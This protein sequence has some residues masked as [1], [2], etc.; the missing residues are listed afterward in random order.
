MF[1][2]LHAPG[3][4]AVLLDCARYFSPLIEEIPPDT[5][6]FDI[7]GLRAIHGTTEQIAQK[8]WLRV[9]IPANLAIAPNPDAAVH[10]ARG[11]KGKI[12]IAQGQEAPALAGLPL[13]LLGGSPE[14]AETL[15]LW[16]LRTFGEFAALPPMGVAA[17]LGDEG[18][19]M[20][21]LA[22]GEGDRLLKVAKDPLEFREEMEPE[23][24]LDLAESVLL[25]AGRMLND[26]CTRLSRQSLATNEIHLRL[27]LERATEYVMSL[28]LPVPMLDAKVFLKLLQLELNQRPP[29]APVEKLF[30]ELKPVKV[31]TTQHDLFLPASP[32]P[33]KLE[34][35]LSRIREMVGPDNLGAPILV[36][37]HRPDSF[38]MGSLSKVKVHIPPP[39]LKLVMRR[40]RPPVRAQVWCSPRGEP[41]RI[42]SSKIEG[43]VIACAGPWAGSGGWWED[44]P[45]DCAEWDVEIT[46]G[47]LLRIHR[48]VRTGIW[49]IDSSYD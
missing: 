16:G 10:A 20:Q 15:D 46:S 18:V 9:G 48:N 19:A 49:A 32:E 47:D 40:F 27:K 22:R 28:R 42:V 26:I 36:D 13:N 29:E 3:N 34:I 41:A 7:R 12:I 43:R 4:M 5:V 1:A 23:C 2:C 39:R 33:E 45:W 8:I 11:I 44:H 25:L 17:R 21:R 24:T 35:T 31:R 30:L 37:T 38:L 6:V 14:F